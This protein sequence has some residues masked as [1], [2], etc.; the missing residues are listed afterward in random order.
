MSDEEKLEMF[1][2]SHS[3]VSLVGDEPWEIFEKKEED[4]TG[5][6]DGVNVLG[7]AVGPFFAIDGKSQNNRFYE[8]KLWDKVIKETNDS[9]THGQML[10]TIGHEQ[11]LDDKAIL[12]GKVSHRVSKLWIDEGKKTG[13]GEILIL[14]TQAGRTLNTL[15]RGGVELSVSSRGFGKYNGEKEGVRLVDSKSYKLETFDIVRKSLEF[16]TPS[17]LW[18]KNLKRSESSDLDN[19]VI[20]T[21]TGEKLKE[22]IMEDKHVESLVQAKMD[23]QEALDQAL[24]RNGELEITVNTQKELIESL[25]EEVETYKSVGS[26][27]EMTEAKSQVSTL[28]ESVESMKEAEAELENY[29]N[30]GTVEEIEELTERADEMAKKYESL[31]G[32]DE[33]ERVFERCEKLIKK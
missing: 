1:E 28:T 6:V 33:I 21:E 25:R 3:L 13:M 7:R 30:L 29:K 10:G 17:L 11:P 24:T 18:L 12:E 8:R 27:E 2:D 15:M 5:V 22:T 20:D 14:N 19:K 23:A 31:G 9:I 26:V 4:K 16:L 32:P